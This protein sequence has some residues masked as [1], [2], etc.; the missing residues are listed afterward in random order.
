[1]GDLY[2]FFEMNWRSGVLFMAAVLVIAVFLIQKTDWLCERLGL[3]SK[4]RLA[5]EDQ[6]KD[7][8]ELK[9]HAK[10]TDENFDKICNSID[11]LKASISKVSVQ[12]KTMQD[13]QD[14]TERNRLR[15]RIGQGY[16]YYEAKG[17]WTRLEQ[18][19]FEGLIQSY[20]AAGGT[21]GK[22]HQVII[23]ASLKWKVID[24]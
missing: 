12:V 22:V 14:E 9:N 7:I 15:D 3:T 6:K 5:E 2:K 10:K 24:E 16:R 4:R 20:E 21:N 8:G 13:K 19:A 1:M 23:P 17:E 18:E 11:E